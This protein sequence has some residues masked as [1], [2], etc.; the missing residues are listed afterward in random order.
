MRQRQETAGIKL[1]GQ[2]LHGHMRESIVRARNSTPVPARI[3][4]E[5]HKVEPVSENETEKQHT[6]E[7]ASEDHACTYPMS[8]G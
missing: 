4:R 3:R 1:V 7:E 2:L 5:A 6:G 8:R